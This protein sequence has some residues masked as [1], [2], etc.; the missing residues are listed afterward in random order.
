MFFNEILNNSL[1]RWTSTRS[2]VTPGVGASCCWRPTPPSHPRSSE[3][4]YPSSCIST[5]RYANVIFSMGVNGKYRLWNGVEMQIS[6]LQWVLNV[7]IVFSCEMQKSFFQWVS[8]ENIVFAMGG[9][10][11]YRLFNGLKCRLL[12]IFPH[13][14]CSWLIKMCSLLFH[15]SD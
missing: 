2:R 8:H 9:N 7:K 10:C 15:L 12:I 6:S 4:G 5:R 14:V 1:F 11:K 13:T 3:T